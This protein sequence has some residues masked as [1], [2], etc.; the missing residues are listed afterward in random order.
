MSVKLTYLVDDYCTSPGLLGEHGLSILIETS[1]A[2]LLFDT[3]L[4]LAL[5]FNASALGVD[6]SSI[7]AVAL[8]HG[9]NDHGGGLKLALERIAHARRSSGKSSAIPVYAHPGVFQD[10]FKKFDSG[11]IKPTGIPFSREEL[12]TLGAKLHFHTEPLEPIPGIILTGEIERGL[13]EVKTR[14][15]FVNVDGEL[16][17][18]SF[19]DD[20]AAI[21]KGDKGLS[22]VLG[23]AHAGVV[24]TLN[25]AAKLT[26]EQHFYGLFGGTH[27]LQADEEQLEMTL[28]AI[29]QRK[30]QVIGFSH[31][32][33]MEAIAYFTK[34]FGG[35]SYKGISGFTIE[36]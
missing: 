10:R 26:G 21:V 28:A 17:P 15:H 32:T 5:D 14:S 7:D 24:N 31:C 33:G 4:G 12:E 36:I 30:I 3:G 11:N 19:I 22:V 2:K 29:E 16:V 13:E 25:Y 34:N 1:G 23:C 20:Q 8:S 27:L 18:D 6:F 35:T 9:H